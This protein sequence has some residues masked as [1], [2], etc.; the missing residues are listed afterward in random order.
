MAFD[1]TGTKVALGCSDKTVK[2]FRK[3]EDGWKQES[4]IKLVGAAGWKIKW[5]R[6]QFGVILAVC[7]LDRIIAL[8]E[9]SLAK[10]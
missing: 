1:E 9:W 6:P 2:I 4:F 5:A 3:Y 8:Y 10:R 7:S